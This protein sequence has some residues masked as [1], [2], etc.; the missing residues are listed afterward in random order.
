[1][2]C[3][4]SQIMLAGSRTVFSE[5]GHATPSQ[6]EVNEHGVAGGIFPEGML[7]Y[8]AIK[9]KYFWGKDEDQSF[10]SFKNVASDHEG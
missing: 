4:D 2:L 3:A 5:R 6:L 10:G 1:M 8:F 7:G 9:V